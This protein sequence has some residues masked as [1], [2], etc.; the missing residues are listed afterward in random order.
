MRLE[1]RLEK[2][3][4]KV[5]DSNQTAT[6]AIAKKTR[7]ENVEKTLDQLISEVPENSVHK[8]KVL[9]PASSRINLIFATIRR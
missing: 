2:Q 5:A 9:N 1:R 6:A 3:G 4:Q 7:P 8:L